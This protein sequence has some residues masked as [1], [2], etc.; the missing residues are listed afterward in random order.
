MRHAF[1]GET[2]PAPRVP[3]AA[4]DAAKVLLAAAA[5]AWLAYRGATE[6][7]YNWQW[8]RVGEYLFFSRE[9]RLHAGPL[10]QGL[11]VTLRIVGASL[12]LAFGL[13]LFTAL[14]RRSSF[15][16]ARLLARAYMELVRNTPLLI[17]IFFVYFVVA[18][19]FSVSRFWSAVWALSLFEGAY[20]SEIFRAG[21][22]SIARGQWE[23]AASLGL[24][25][26]QAY[27]HVILPQAVRRVL[28]PLTSQ[29]VSLVKDS[30]LV[31]TIAVYDL[32]MQARSVVSETFLAFEV[33]FLV[34]AMYLA[35]TVS[36]SVAAQAMERRLKV[37]T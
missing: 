28:P 32:T 24:S 19:V 10:V 20:M 36:L 15:F 26:F 18:R 27:V 25:P 3:A 22:A 8:H 30:A 17:Q 13:G 5:M 37:R 6:L 33:W 4:W 23:A 7:G 35:V 14:L 34:A 21:I 1:P 9:G 16:S 12:L 29:T 11:F 2:D 31:S